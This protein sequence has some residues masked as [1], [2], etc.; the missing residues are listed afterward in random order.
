MG[1]ASC[2]IVENSHPY[3]T[4]LWRT[5]YLEIDLKTNND[6][7]KRLHF[8][9]DSPM[10]GPTYDFHEVS[11]ATYLGLVAIDFNSVMEMSFHFRFDGPFKIK[12]T[13]IRILSLQD[14]FEFGIIS[15]QYASRKSNVVTNGP[16]SS[17]FWKNVIYPLLGFHVFHLGNSFVR[18]Y[19]VPRCSIDTRNYGCCLF[20]IFCQYEK[21]LIAKWMCWTPLARFLWYGF[22]KRDPS[23]FVPQ[24]CSTYLVHFAMVPSNWLPPPW[25]N[26]FFPGSGVI[27]SSKL[28]HIPFW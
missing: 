27:W 14:A 2:L 23:V 8:Y 24:E 28:R 6:Y 10:F 22:G 20:G 12:R 25:F 21:L 26:G 16:Q 9:S 13:G 19:C 17:G 1:F 3:G 18:R 4:K 11:M 5:L 15:D 7:E